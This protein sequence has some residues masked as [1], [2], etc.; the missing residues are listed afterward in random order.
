MFGIG[1]TSIPALQNTNRVTVM[2]RSLLEEEG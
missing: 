1:V 2:G